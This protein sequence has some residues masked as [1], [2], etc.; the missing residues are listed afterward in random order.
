MPSLARS[1][2][3][4]KEKERA[5]NEGSHVPWLTVSSSMSL[6][7]KAA[8]LTEHSLGLSPGLTSSSELLPSPGLQGSSAVT[9][10][11]KLQ[12][13]EPSPVPRVERALHMFWCCPSATD[14]TGM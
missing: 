3:C 5:P 8:V 11:L 6:T 13:I 10:C 1:Q 9:V 12:P 14:S 4:Q 7:T 2:H